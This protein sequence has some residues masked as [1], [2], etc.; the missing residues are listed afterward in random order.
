M[1]T[2][3]PK[4]RS[5]R[6]KLIFIAALITGATLLASS[7]VFLSLE[8]YLS[9]HDSENKLTV[10]SAV[11]GQQ[12][13]LS[14][15]ANNLTALQSTLNGLK[16]D[17]NIVRACLYDS[18]QQLL[19]GYAINDKTQCSTFWQD[20]TT[21]K[22][23]HAQ[24]TTA[25]H[26]SEQQ[27]GVLYIESA[28]MQ[29]AQHMQKFLLAS[30][31]IFA[32]VITLAL[33]LS[34]SLQN[35]VLRP[36]RELNYTLRNIM[37][38][39]D[40]SIRA[41]ASNDSSLSEL[42]ELFNTLLATI[43]DDNNSLKNS[44][45]RFRTLT[46]LAPVG[47]FQLDAQQ[48]FLYANQRWH[49]ITRVNLEQPNLSDWLRVIHP[50]DLKMLQPYWQA[51][52]EHKN[53]FSEEFRLLNPERDVTW[54]QLLISAIHNRHGELMGYLG[55]ITDITELKN[56]Q[57][58]METLAFYDALTGLANRRLFRDRLESSILSAQRHNKS[59]ALLFL[60]MDQFK[61]INDSLGHD[62]GDEL[63]I[64]VAKRLK[65]CVRETDT[66]SRIGGDEFTIL[67]TDIQSNSDVVIVAEKLLQHLALPIQVHGQEVSTS[68]SIGITL[69]PDDS[70]DANILMK[71]ADMAMY[72]AKE[73]GR[74]NF[75]FFSEEMNRSVLEHIELEKELEDALAQSQFML[76]FQP[77][78]SIHD[79]NVVGIECLLRWHHPSKG[80]IVPDKFIPI[81]EETGKILAIGEWVLQE[82]CQQMALLIERGYMLASNRIA[83]NLSA[84]QFT[85]PELLSRIHN[86]LKVSG[87]PASNL[88]LELTESILMEDVENAIAT[89]H[90]IKELGITIAIDDFGTGYSSLSY[91]KRFPID[92][93]KV[94]RSFVMDIPDDQNDM[95]ITAAVIAMAHKLNLS[96]VAEGV[97]SKEQLSFL[98]S[99]RC[100]EGQGYFF[101]PPLYI[102]ELKAFLKG[103]NPAKVLSL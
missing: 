37:N 38:K 59:V 94:D 32:L 67:L 75:Q 33:L 80:P 29:L 60:D 87:L 93:L 64:A 90:S 19:A 8:Y 73:L 43:E 44:E 56:A 92:V 69:T 11:I 88:E 7:I 35:T 91:I 71:N 103:Y 76:A 41:V 23:L 66:V 10:L 89:M 40:Y 36:L 51:L 57:L 85:D 50:T 61:R 39:K 53:S 18:K 24:K 5:L 34:N 28:N 45:T 22:M 97:E 68:V 14:S 31:M 42:V 12:A 58:Q 2:S 101:S 25:V 46:S 26:F 63:L 83:V 54:A 65:E 70:T 84:R 13:S 102:N 9:Q 98:H 52:I 55:T 95:A 99:N 20:L 30:S 100:T 17:H 62:A 81:A 27:S 21:P 49:D 16:A 74:N 79:F 78:V 96:I 82:A 86:A 4:K 1:L 15:H 77:K 3:K 72:Q 47:I 48:N 6:G